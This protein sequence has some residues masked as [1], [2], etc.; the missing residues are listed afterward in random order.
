M[1]SIAMDLEAPTKRMPKISRDE[2]LARLAQVKL[3]Q[4]QNRLSAE[5]PIFKAITYE[6]LVRS[7]SLRTLILDYDLTLFRQDPKPIGSFQRE[8]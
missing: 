5:H 3:E 4:L 8:Y 6:D 7:A 1:T 2:A